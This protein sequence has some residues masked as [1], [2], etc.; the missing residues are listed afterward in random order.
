M[1]VRFVAQQ[2]MLGLSECERLCATWSRNT[3]ELAARAGWRGMSGD[4]LSVTV[5]TA[6]NMLVLSAGSNHGI[7]WAAMGS[8]LP[9]LRNEALL[10]LGEDTSNWSFDGTGEAEKQFWPILYGRPEAI[11]PRIASLLSCCPSTTARQLRFH[12]QNDVELLPNA[13]YSSGL[14]SRTP[15]FTIDA[16][17]LAARVRE[18]SAGPLFTAKAAPPFSL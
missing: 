4:R 5:G 14:S 2:R 1:S 15:R 17:N 3:E 6:V 11:R 13:Q 7:E 18:S 9:S 10:K 12:T 8:W 16:H